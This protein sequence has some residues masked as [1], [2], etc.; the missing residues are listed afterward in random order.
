M[1]MT[2]NLK[3]FLEAVSQDKKLTDQFTKAETPEAVIALAA[4]KG[5]ALNLEDIKPEERSGEVSDEELDAVAGVKTCVCVAGGGG[6]SGGDDYTCWCV[7]GGS[8]SGY[9][10]HNCGYYGTSDG[11]EN[12][13]VCLG[14]GQG[15]SVNK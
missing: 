13:C 2:D 1:T 12:R 5:F 6:E 7:L 14:Y 11:E 15:D 3:K 9:Y 10:R 8:G 4:E